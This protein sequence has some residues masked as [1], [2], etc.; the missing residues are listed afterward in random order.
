MLMNSELGQYAS[1]ASY[2]QYEYVGISVGIVFC[3][4]IVLYCI[5][6]L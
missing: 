1:N 3:V 6:F 5:L 4:C 2:F